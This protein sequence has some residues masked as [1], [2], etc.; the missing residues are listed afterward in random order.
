MKSFGA[1]EYDFDGGVKSKRNT[2]LER[3][4]DKSTKENQVK[5]QST[6]TNMNLNYDDSK[7]LILEMET[8]NHETKDKIIITPNGLIGS[9]RKNREDND[10]FAYFGYKDPNDI[11]IIII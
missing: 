8:E 6:R 4:N 10:N 3:R 1:N 9:L 2:A 11:V 5:H 7:T